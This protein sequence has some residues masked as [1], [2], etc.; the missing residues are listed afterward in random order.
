MA[1]DILDRAYSNCHLVLSRLLNGNQTV[2]PSSFVLLCTFIEPRTR[3]SKRRYF[4]R[5]AESNIEISRKVT[6]FPLSPLLLP[7]YD[8]ARNGLY[9]RCGLW[10]SVDAFTALSTFISRGGM[11]ANFHPPVPQHLLCSASRYV[12]RKL[13]DVSGRS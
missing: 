11:S 2:I 4:V 8:R 6:H 1:F 5:D 7:I 12:S 3:S 9:S 13:P 10:F